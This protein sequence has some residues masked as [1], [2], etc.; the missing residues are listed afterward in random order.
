MQSASGVLVY[1]DHPHS[2]VTT[3]YALR[4]QRVGI[5]DHIGPAA[6]GGAGGEQ[7]ETRGHERST[8]EIAAHRKIIGDVL[9]RSVVQPRQRDM[10]DELAPFGIEPQALHQPL[11]LGLQFDQRPARLDGS[12]H[13][14]RF[15]A[16]ETL[17]AL[18][19]D[20]ERLA[21]DSKQQRG[22]FVRRHAVDISDEAQG[23]VIIFGIDPACAGKAATQ[24][25]K[26]LADLGRNFQSC[27]QTRHRKILDAKARAVRLTPD[28]NSGDE[29]PIPNFYPTYVTL[30]SM[31]HALSGKLRKKRGVRLSIADFSTALP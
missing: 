15:L 27:K 6:G 12:D 5:L 3:R 10:G 22:D 7:H 11:Q 19:L 16:A 9:A 28:N 20:L 1:M 2:R 29:S 26:L 8:R 4:T 21:V 31:R 24:I 30:R 23:D 17:Q 14:A 18:H 25:G 13:R